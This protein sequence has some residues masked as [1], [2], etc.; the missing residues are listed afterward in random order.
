MAL[1]SP[2][3]P[4]LRRAHSWRGWS[5]GTCVIVRTNCRDKICEC[6]KS[7]FPGRKIARTNSYTENFLSVKDQEGYLGCSG[8]AVFFYCTYMF[9]VKE[10]EVSQKARQVTL[11]KTR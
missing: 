11:F 4:G 6:V 10:S 1:Q 5:S 9:L 3:T 2:V 7:D 8:H